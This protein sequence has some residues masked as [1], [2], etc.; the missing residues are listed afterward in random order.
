MLDWYSFLVIFS[1]RARLFDFVFMLC[2]EGPDKA[3]SITVN[4][5]EGMEKKQEAEEL[6][7]QCQKGKFMLDRFSPTTV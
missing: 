3:L 1:L 6:K 4:A 2:S 7:N 5:L